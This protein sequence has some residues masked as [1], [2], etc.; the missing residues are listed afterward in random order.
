MSYDNGMPVST[1][2]FDELVC[3]G[4]GS[5]QV[6]NGPDPSVRIV[7]PSASL[8]RVR[9]RNRGMRLV[10]SFRV[11]PDPWRAMMESGGSVSVVVTID[12]ISR[13]H[14]QGFCSIKLGSENHPLALGDTT[15][16][17]GGMGVVSGNVSAER[18]TVRNR[19]HGQIR[20]AG[21]VRWLDMANR[22]IRALDC[23]ELVAQR[24]KA[25]VSNVG[26][27]DLMVL[28]ELSARVDGIGGISYRGDPIVHR[29][30]GGMGRLEKIP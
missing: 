18:L 30:G 2:L 4:A 13:I 25:T 11:G 5:V 16:I 20:L 19:G 23:S 27:I 3:R 10:I 6:V 7:G 14:A 28:D 1:G 12:S 22:G 9:I 29:R 15:L 21:D 17:H 26:R 24:A 8:N